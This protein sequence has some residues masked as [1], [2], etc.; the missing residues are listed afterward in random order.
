M[1][2]IALVILIFTGWLFAHHAYSQCAV[3]AG[4][5]TVI[6]KGYPPFSCVTIHTVATGQGSLSYLWSTGDT[7]SSLVVCDSSGMYT[8]TVTDSSGCV[9]TDTVVVTAID[10]SCHPNGKKVLVCHV[11]KGNPAMAHN[12]CISVHA[13]AAHLAHGD[14]LGGCVSAPVPNC[15]VN[16]GPDI[17]V[18]PGSLPVLDAGAGWAT[19]LW[20]DSSNGQTLVADTAGAYWVWVT[21]SSGCTATD[22]IVI[23]YDSL[24]LSVHAGPDQVID[25]GDSCITLTA[26]VSGGLPPYG[27]IWSS[28]DSSATTTVCDTVSQVYYVT[29]TDSAGCTGTDSVRVVVRTPVCGPKKVLVCHIPPGNN[30]KAHT[31]CIS[32]HALKAHLA[33]GDRLGCCDTIAIGP[34]LAP[35]F[36]LYNQISDNI[37]L[38]YNLQED[39]YVIVRVVSTS[40]KIAAIV[41]EGAIPAG[42]GFRSLNV[43]ELPNGIY[44][45]EIR[46]QK[47]LL[48]HDKFVLAR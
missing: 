21:D 31:I 5:D 6:Y 4:N 11:P 41:Y 14:Y 48:V 2:K 44:V 12:I 26:A 32:P 15:A 40:G 36:T 1:K 22:T 9:A 46:S 27:F 3:T 34:R 8:I 38:A 29:V 24:G 35:P 37:E 39:D 28:G 23:S 42:Q 45:A 47:G 17:T 18:C 7:T 25:C 43:S 30:K 16:L 13:V 19:Y 10:V 20:S 33:H